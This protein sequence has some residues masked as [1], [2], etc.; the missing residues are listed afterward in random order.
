MLYNAMKPVVVY[1]ELC[2]LRVKASA[3]FHLYT[4]LDAFLKVCHTIALFSRL[5]Y[6]SVA[7]SGPFRIRFTGFCRTV[8]LICVAKLFLTNQKQV[9]LVVQFVGHRTA[10]NCSTFLLRTR[11][12][13][14]QS[15]C[16][17]VPGLSSRCFFPASLCWNVQHFLLRPLKFVRRNEHTLAA[18]KQTL[19]RQW[20]FSQ[21]PTAL[22]S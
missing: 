15:S 20:K 17:F 10:M 13:C 14:A 21:S 12:L 1:R 22:I 18:L 6:I 9:N 7:S 5:C 19:G 16:F 4:F 3:S 2:F 11:L 8:R